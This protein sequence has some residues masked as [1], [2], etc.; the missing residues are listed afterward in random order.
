MLWSEVKAS[1]QWTPETYQ[2]VR[3]GGHDLRSYQNEFCPTLQEQAGRNPVHEPT[4]QTSKSGD[5]FCHM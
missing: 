1:V 2:Q 5:S 4:G 3:V